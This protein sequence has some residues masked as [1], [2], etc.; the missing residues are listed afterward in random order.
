MDIDNVKTVA[1]QEVSRTTMT[2]EILHPTALD[3]MKMSPVDVANHLVGGEFVGRRIEGRTQEVPAED[4]DGALADMGGIEGFFAER[5]P[6]PLD[7][8]Y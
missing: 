8:K 1:N 6:S 3:P 5:E 7:G 4:V 2:Y